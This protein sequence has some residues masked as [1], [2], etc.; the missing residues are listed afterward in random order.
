MSY[1]PGW[2]NKDSAWSHT[3]C[4]CS[5]SRCLLKWISVLISIL[6]HFHHPPCVEVHVGQTVVDAEVLDMEEVVI[7]VEVPS[8]IVGWLLRVAKLVV[9]TELENLHVYL[10]L[11]IKMRAVCWLKWCKVKKLSLM[12]FWIWWRGSIFIFL[13]TFLSKICFFLSKI[14]SKK[15]RIRDK[16]QFAIKVC[17]SEQNMICDNKSIFLQLKPIYVAANL[18]IQLVWKLAS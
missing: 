13:L 9:H 11:R 5:W 7:R 17:I 6:F 2:G 8:V 1:S 14:L 12:Q 4:C 16:I 3:W 15:A 10:T 18:E